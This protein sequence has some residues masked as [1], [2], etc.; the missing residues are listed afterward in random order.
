MFIDGLLPKLFAFDAFEE[1]G[2]SIRVLPIPK[3]AEQFRLH[4]PIARAFY[5]RKKGGDTVEHVDQEHTT[6]Y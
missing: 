5:T 1:W 2:R 3:P 6:I 4:P